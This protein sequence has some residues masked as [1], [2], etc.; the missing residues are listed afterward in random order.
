MCLSSDIPLMAARSSFVFEQH[1]AS[2]FRDQP[3]AHDRHMTCC[4]LSL[5]VMGL[6]VKLHGVQWNII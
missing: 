2:G 5:A 3:L 1:V 4:S 6:R